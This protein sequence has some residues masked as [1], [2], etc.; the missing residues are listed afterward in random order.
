MI[1]EFGL[2]SEKKFFR[3]PKTLGAFRIH[4]KQKTNNNALKRIE[5][6]HILLAYRYNYVDK[7]NLIG[8]LKRYYFRNRRALWYLKRGGVL[9]LLKRFIISYKKN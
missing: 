3:I 6:E 4:K 9:N 1:L 8:C 2:L 7:Y 5:Q